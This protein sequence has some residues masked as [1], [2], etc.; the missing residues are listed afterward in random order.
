MQNLREGGSDY[1]SHHEQ[2][3]I[4]GYSPVAAHVRL[5]STRTIL[6]YPIAQRPKGYVWKDGDGKGGLRRWRIGC[7]L[8]RSREFVLTCSRWQFSSNRLDYAPHL[9]AFVLPDSSC[10]F[11]IRGARGCT[12]AF[13][14]SNFILKLSISLIVKEARPGRVCQRST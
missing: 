6:F 11:A 2:K 14:W 5:H 9:S 1:I 4:R 13:V 10:E 8:R 3:R 7:R 12:R